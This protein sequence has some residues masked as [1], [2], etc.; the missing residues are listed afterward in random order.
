MNFAKILL[1]N[2]ELRI[3]K[4]TGKSKERGRVKKSVKYQRTQEL[5]PTE[6]GAERW[7]LN[8]GMGEE[9]EARLSQ[10]KIA[11]KEYEVNI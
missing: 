9:A 1:K 10:T 11:H 5:D 3:R 7:M 6:E 4:W 8:L 2:K